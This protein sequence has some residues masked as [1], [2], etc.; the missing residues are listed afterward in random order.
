MEVDGAKMDDVDELVSTFNDEVHFAAVLSILQTAGN[1]HGR[2][3]MDLPFTKDL[4]FTW[5][6]FSSK[7]WWN[8]EYKLANIE[9]KRT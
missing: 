1:L 3:Y 5:K 9:I 7:L 4:P 8:A 2:S 6:I